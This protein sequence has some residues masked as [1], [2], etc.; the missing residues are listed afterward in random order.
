MSVVREVSYCRHGKVAVIEAPEY[1]DACNAPRVRETAIA[2]QSGG[3]TGIVF[4]LAGVTLIDNAALAVIAATVIRLG[5]AGGR[6]AVTGAAPRL[7]RLLKETRLATIA[8]MF[9]TSKDAVTF[10][11]ARDGTG[12]EAAQ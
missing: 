9:E 1:F 2:L 8:P 10:L 3:V 5:P 6:V 12:S 7:A 11:Q 4:D